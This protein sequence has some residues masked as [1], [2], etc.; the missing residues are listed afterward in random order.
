MHFQQTPAQCLQKVFISL[1][2][3]LSLYTLKLN[4]MEIY[5]YPFNN[6]FIMPKYFLF[7]DK[8][9]KMEG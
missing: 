3:I 9:F 4:L 7:K 5:V 1:S 6:R 2:H 8:L